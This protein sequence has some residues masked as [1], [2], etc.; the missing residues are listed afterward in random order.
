MYIEMLLLR[1]ISSIIL[2]ILLFQGI[3]NH[4][5]LSKKNLYVEAGRWVAVFILTVFIFSGLQ[6]ASS[7]PV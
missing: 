2:L 6:I 7:D 1:I 5:N 3:K 4:I